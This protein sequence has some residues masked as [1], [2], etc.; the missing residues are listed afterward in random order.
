[1]KYISLDIETTG[2]DP[3]FDQILEIGAILEDTDNPVSFGDAP[4]FHCY[5]WHDRIHGSPYALSMHAEI[6]RKIATKTPA[7]ASFL[8]P[9]DVVDRFID[10]LVSYKIDRVNFAG[11]N[12]ASFDLQFLKQLPD[13]NKIQYRHRSLDPAILYWKPED[14]SLPSMPECLRRAKLDSQVAHTALADAWQ[15]IQL[16]RERL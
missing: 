2:L 12:F 13:W 5:V 8:S 10:W 14:N 16:L 3:E 7:S 1:M 6:L 15:V 9:L 4:K 11:K